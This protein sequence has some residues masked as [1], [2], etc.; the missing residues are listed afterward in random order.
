MV[1]VLV[2]FFFVL[3]S[4]LHCFPIYNLQLL[5]SKLFL[6]SP[7]LFH[8]HTHTT[9]RTE[10]SLNCISTPPRLLRYYYFSFKNDQLSL[11]VFRYTGQASAGLQK[12]YPAQV[13]I[14]MYAQAQ[15]QLVVHLLVCL[16][17]ARSCSLLLK[18]CVSHMG[19]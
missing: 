14:Q 11:T 4:F 7:S 1:I 16:A 13:Q 8:T 2:V 3:S 9:P 15:A 5:L 18:V 12:M 19:W 10:L 17:R 6:V